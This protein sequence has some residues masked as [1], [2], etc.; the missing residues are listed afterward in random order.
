MPVKGDIDV[1]GD[2]VF[3]IDQ[4]GIGYW[5]KAMFG[6]P[7]TTGAGDPYSHVFKPAAQ[8]SL[9]IER[10]YG[11]LAS[12]KYEL[13]NGCKVSKAAF[14][15]GDGA[16]PQCTASIMGAKSTIG[17]ASF[18]GTAT[19]FTW[20]PY[21]KPQMTIEEGGSSI[22]YL[23]K[24]DMQIDFGL[25]GDTVCIGSSGERT[26]IN[27]GILEVTGSATALFS[28]EAL[29]TKATAGTESSL[30]VILTA[31]VNRNI[32]FFIPELLWEPSSPTVEGPAGLKLTLNFRGYY[33]DAASAAAVAIT[34][35][36]GQASYA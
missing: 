27:D 35:K 34:L 7:T 16:F 18:D 8:S 31:S 11:A 2:I 12:A 21:S 14:S 24:V 19:T 10:Q 20:T 22:A 23:Q 1:S 4:I 3:G 30:K 15:F 28:S 32:E 5:L 29:L 25:D 13:F 36:N 6:A 9:C 33:Q 17:A 26:G